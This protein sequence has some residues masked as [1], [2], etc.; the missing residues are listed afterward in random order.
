MT[1]AAVGQPVTRRFF[2]LGGAACAF[3]TLLPREAQAKEGIA[4]ASLCGNYRF[5]GGNTERRAVS[6]AIERAVSG[7]NILVRGTA[8]E[9][10]R[11]ANPIPLKLALTAEDGLFQIAYRSERFRAPLDGKKVRVRSS[12]GEAASLKLVSSA[13]CLDQVFT[14]ASGT[15]VNRLRPTAEGLIVEVTLRAEQLPGPMS[16]RLTYRRE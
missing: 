5:A 7:M 10:L 12:A 1:E 2:V 4:I 3:A 14:S 6:G 9:R 11:W 13:T 8:R 16:Y 15:R